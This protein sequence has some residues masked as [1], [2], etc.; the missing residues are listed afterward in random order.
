M[1]FQSSSQKAL[2]KKNTEKQYV[3]LYGKGKQL[4]SSQTNLENA[5]EFIVRSFKTLLELQ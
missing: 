1:Q 2:K 3:N 4:I 5:A